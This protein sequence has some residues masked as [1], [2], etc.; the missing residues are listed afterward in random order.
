M[1]YHWPTRDGWIAMGVFLGAAIIAGGW[2]GLLA[3]LTFI[4][5]MSVMGHILLP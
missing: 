3:M 1:T 4:V 5:F 2:I